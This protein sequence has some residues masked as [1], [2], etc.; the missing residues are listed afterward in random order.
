MDD[1]SQEFR[2]ARMEVREEDM[3]CLTERISLDSDDMEDSDDALS[4]PESET[5]KTEKLDIEDIVQDVS[6]L[7]TEE[8]VENNQQDGIQVRPSMNLSTF[9]NAFN[10]AGNKIS[11]AH[12]GVRDERNITCHN[13][14]T[15]ETNNLCPEIFTFV[16]DEEDWGKEEE[17]CGRSARDMTHEE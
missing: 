17:I 14:N 11:G 6:K 7:F 15:N 1:G 12:R 16:E 13:P 3:D 8:V 4:V 10:S 5:G 2:E 9:A